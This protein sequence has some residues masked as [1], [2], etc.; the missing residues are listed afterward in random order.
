MAE[1]KKS[2]NIIIDAVK[3]SNNIILDALIKADKPTDVLKEPVAIDVLDAAKV[4][5]IAFDYNIIDLDTAVRKDSV[6]V[7]KGWNPWSATV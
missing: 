5:Q 1:F 4:D 7:C 3:E 6:K 2:N